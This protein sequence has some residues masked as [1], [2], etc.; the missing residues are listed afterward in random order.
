MAT[1][2]LA[3]Y[4]AGIKKRRPH[5]A[6]LD[7]DPAILEYLRCMLS[8][9]CSLSLYT[10]A[11]DLFVN[12]KVRQTP[13]LLLVDGHI[14][15]ENT[16]ALIT[17]I[18]AAKPKLP[19][20]QLSCSTDLQDVV[21]AMRA[22]VRDIILKPFRKIDIDRV[23]NPYLAEISGSADDTWSSEIPLNEDV[24]FVHSCKKMREIQRQCALVARADIPVLV[25]GES[26][27]GKRY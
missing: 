6:I 16:L 13:E 2:Q 10:N 8:D 1:P 4:S 23:V 18:R 5:I 26:G 9:R 21:L 11:A 20:I 17:A 3:S 19:V 12:F 27:T 22:G 7:S 15:K 14:E 24:S 25:L